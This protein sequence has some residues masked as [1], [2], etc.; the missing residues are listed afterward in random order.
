[1]KLK[2]FL[3]LIFFI[4][5]L[6][7]PKNYKGAELRTK[8]TFLYGRFESSFK[9]AGKEGTLST[10]F[11]Y[12]DGLP[13]DTW[14]T[15]KWNEI[16]IEIM[17]R[18]NNDVQF[19][20]IS[21]GQINHVRHHLV[22]FNPA[23]DYHTYA[24]EWTPDY[25]AWFIDGVEVYRQTEDFVKTITRP[26]KLMFNMWIPNYPN[27]A[28]VWN[29]QILPAFT[30]YDWAA[31]YEYTP[32]N[33][34]Y[35]SSN[36]FSFKWKD[37][38]NSFDPSSWEKATHTWDGNNSDFV[39]ENVVFKD[40]KMILCLT[41]PNELGN[42]DNRP[43]TIISA[44]AVTDT[45]IQIFFSEELD[46]N[47][48][49]V[50][51]RYAI[52]GLPPTKSASLLSD[53]R[54]VEVE[55]DKLNLNSLPAIIVLA[56][57][58]DKFIPANT[59]GNMAKSIIANS[60]FKFP[61]KINIGGNNYNEFISDREFKTDTSNYGFMEG[62]KGGSFNWEINNTDDDNVFQTE[63]NGLAKYVVRIPNGN[64]RVKLLFA[65]NYLNQINQRL[66]DVYL[67]GNKV[68][69][70][71]DIVKEVG[72]QTALVKTFD[73]LV[74]NYLLDVHFGAQVQRPL[75]NGIIIEQLSTNVGIEK[76]VPNDF[77]LMQ[78]YPNPF[79]PK[80]IINY[81]LN[82][83]DYITL[84][85]YD[86]LG[87]KI[88]N[89]V[90]EFKEAGQHSAQFSVLNHQYSSGIYFYTLNALRTGIT[91]TKKMILIK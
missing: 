68:I 41:F 35:G 89:L 42:T 23:T 16:D 61:L 29:D 53:N 19:N 50:P 47:S 12:F 78:N 58:K 40:G 69:E 32:G 62:I 90:N 91:E 80:T 36:N 84:N 63:I 38:F 55:V 79:N 14:A 77:Q 3:L 74:D 49:E 20:T 56:G 82:H 37:D 13:S 27:W 81:H 26:Q 86:S 72:P 76:S 45:K 64:Y 30:F 15:S 87:R 73:V 51:S 24:F 60:Q 33:G 54:T 21:P 43:P 57:L 5:S 83:S 8:Q 52:G 44:R 67:Q 2:T 34:N 46:K 6:V 65:E 75:I 9:A 88:A 66:F 11:T 70:K 48:A 4:P 28:G 17:G 85:V 10:M 25:I 22:D 18:Y 71:M 59:S 39:Q 7:V 31:Y 1:M